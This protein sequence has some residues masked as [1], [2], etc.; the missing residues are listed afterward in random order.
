MKILLTGASGFIGGHIQTVLEQSGY[1][2]VACSRQ[3]GFDFTKMLSADDW[4]PHLEGVDAVINA[5]GIIVETKQQHFDV[6]HRQAPIALFKAC[7][8]A[9]V[10]RV[11]QVSALGVDDEAFTPYQLSKRAA[12]DHLRQSGLDWFVLRP[13]LVYGEGGASMAMFRQLA[14]LPVIPLVGDGEYQVQPVHISDVVAAV[15]QCLESETE[16][17]QTVDVVGAYPLSFAEWLQTIRRS[18]GR[19]SALLLKTPFSLMLTVA[20]FGKHLMPM[21]SPDNLRMLQ[22]GNTS[23]VSALKNF[24]GRSP[25]TVEEGLQR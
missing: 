8:A 2:V 19:K 12:D 11:I 25:L 9:G 21:M 1:E 16:V 6:I 3:S 10:Q 23:D 24:L 17:Q 20:G 4:L 14:S 7:E 18:G 22:A 15:M 13:S 5:V